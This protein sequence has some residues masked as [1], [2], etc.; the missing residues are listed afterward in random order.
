MKEGNESIPEMST[1]RY[2][3]LKNIAT[4]V[5]RESKGSLFHNIL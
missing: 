4:A 2:G 5:N 1:L 3:H